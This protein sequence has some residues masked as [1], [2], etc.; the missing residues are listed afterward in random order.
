MSALLLTEVPVVKLA[1]VPVP[2]KE[3]IIRR[4]L[5]LRNRQGLHCQPA[6]LLVKTL[7]NFGCKATV[8]ANGGRTDGRSIVGLLMR[9]AGY[10]TIFNFALEGADAVAAMK[11]IQHLFETNFAG[12]YDWDEA[13]PNLPA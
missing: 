2:I 8:E 6:V 10:G 5:V 12:P 7:Q 11:S 3:R 1:A 13:A 4:A 9:A